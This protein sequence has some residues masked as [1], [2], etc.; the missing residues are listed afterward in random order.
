MKFQ[1][2]DRLAD[3]VVLP[4]LASV[5]SQGCE[6]TAETLAYIAVADE[7]KLYLPAAYPSMYQYCLGELH[8]SEDAAAK[9]IQ[10]ARAARQFPAIFDAVEQGRLHLSGACMLAPHLSREN[11]AE[12]IEAAT[13]RSK[14]RIETLLAERFPSP[15]APTLVMAI[16]PAGANG[17]EGQEHVCESGEQHAPGHVDVHDGQLAARRLAPDAPRAKVTPLA[18][19]R[20]KVEF[21]LDGDAHRDLVQAQA[22]LGRAV[23]Y[24]DVAEVFKRA[25]REYVRHLKRRKC[26]ATERPRPC[27][28]RRSSDPR[29]VPAAVARAVWE[30]DGNQCTF[31]SDEGH[32]CEERS[33]LELD[34]V[35]PVARGGEATP[36]NLRLVCRPHNQHAADLTYGKGFMDEKRSEAQLQ[37]A[38]AKA[39]KAAANAARARERA[40]A[41]E[42]LAAAGDVIPGL[43]ILGYRGE[44]LRDAARLAAAIPDATTEVRMHYV[45]KGL[46]R[47]SMSRLTH[48]ARSPV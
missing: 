21:T 23:P 39:Q 25:L 47:A 22:L 35:I 40:A 45:I 10:A 19:Q 48:G 18:P 11:A 37:A 1:Q 15:D 8:M 43:R 5:V 28:R 30:R 9:R 17:P 32:R 24:G 16:E 42:G 6:N 26:F 36:D 46:G 34:H 38:E 14:A 20:F 4:G 41:A 29:H 33:G 12:L 2:V 27:P 7:R 13:H 31:V 44:D 3:H